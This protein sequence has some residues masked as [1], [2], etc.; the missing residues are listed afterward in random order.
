MSQSNYIHLPWLWLLLF[1]A[2]CSSPQQ[3]T[4]KVIDTGATLNYISPEE[5]SIGDWLTYVAATSFPEGVMTVKLGDHYEQ[6][7][8]KLPVLGGGGWPDYTIRAFLRTHEKYVAVDFY[9]ACSDQIVN[10]AVGQAA[11]D[12]IK[13]YELMDLPITGITYEQAMDYVSYLQDVMNSCDVFTQGLYRYECFLPTPEAF[14]IYEPKWD[15]L[16]A[17]GC[18]LFN[19]KNSLCAAC[20]NSKKIMKHPIFSK[21]GVEPTYTWGYFPDQNGVKNYK[22][23]VAEMT[24]VKGVAKGGSCMH[25]ASEA[26]EGRSQSYDGPA[27]WLGFRVW[28][29]KALL[30]DEGQ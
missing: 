2:S 18:N 14:D 24:S 22:G 15:S 29:R 1:L 25:Y 26:Y 5:V 16:N 27:M 7:Q 19:F 11:A 3:A 21:T 12:S 23:N 9:N 17:Q 28:Y 6:L 4:G 10:L 30:K 13:K 20:P 8:S